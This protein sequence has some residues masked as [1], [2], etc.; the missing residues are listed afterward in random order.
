MVSSRRLPGIDIEQNQEAVNRA[1]AMIDRL[2]SMLRE[3]PSR[4]R[5]TRLASLA[6]HLTDRA[7]LLYAVGQPIELVRSALEAA[8]VPRIEILEGRS[9]SDGF[10]FA[11]VN[12][13]PRPTGGY[14]GRI[15]M[16]APDLSIGNAQFGHETLLIALSL[17]KV[18][19]AR[20]IAERIW[21]PPNAP[22]VGKG[23]FAVYDQSEQLLAYSAGNAILARGARSESALRALVWK[24]S[25][26]HVA[27]E[28]SVLQSLVRG[29]S[30]KLIDALANLVR[31]H[32]ALATMPQNRNRP[33]YFLCF[34]ALG[35]GMHA[36]DSRV[37]VRDEIPWDPHFAPRE[38]TDANPKPSE[39]RGAISI[40]LAES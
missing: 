2:T 13:V 31:V 11:D 7:L 8:L 38:F 5:Q 37:L 26:S 1:D 19:E 30:T 34:A 39:G 16:G 27:A 20:S 3:D 6:D 12:L 10:V 24:A 35:W 14:L 23:N 32:S 18:N 40:P 9:S 22:Y 21:D 33:E 25:D 4:L 28:A 15:S 36:L 29:D 17:G